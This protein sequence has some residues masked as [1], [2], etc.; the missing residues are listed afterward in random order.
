MSPPAPSGPGGPRTPLQLVPANLVEIGDR[1]GADTFAL[2]GV[3]V[4]FVRHGAAVP[5]RAVGDLGDWLVPAGPVGWRI[6]PNPPPNSTLAQ[7]PER[8][9]QSAG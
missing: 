8:L 1:L 4:T 5:V 7:P 9:R 6:V 3:H 2:V